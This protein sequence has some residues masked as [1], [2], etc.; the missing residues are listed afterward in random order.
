MDAQHLQGEYEGEAQSAC[1]YWQ[2]MLFTMYV[3]SCSLP[4]QEMYEA[5]WG[6]SDQKKLKEL[7]NENAR[8][9]IASEPNKELPSPLALIHFRL[10]S[11]CTALDA[12]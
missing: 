7:R 8:F 9:L 6:W 10:A 4:V 3:H 2:S 5:V 1:H 12:I 11:A